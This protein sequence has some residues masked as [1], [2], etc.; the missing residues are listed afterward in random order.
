MPALPGL[1]LERKD[2]AHLADLLAAPIINQR[3]MKRRQVRNLLFVEYL[4][5]GQRLNDSRSKT[6][7]RTVLHFQGDARA[8]RESLAW[9]HANR[10]SSFCANLANQF[11]VCGSQQFGIESALCSTNHFRVADHRADDTIGGLGSWRVIGRSA[12]KTRER[13]RKR[14]KRNSES[15]SRAAVNCYREILVKIGKTHKCRDDLTLYRMFS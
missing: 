5:S 7:I 9:K 2:S 10:I 11:A 8:S 12:N 6:A 15:R 3:S 14:T 13:K 4:K 1:M